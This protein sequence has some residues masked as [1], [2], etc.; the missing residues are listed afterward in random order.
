MFPPE[1]DEFSPLAIKAFEQWAPGAR[2]NYWPLRGGHSGAVVLKVEVRNA[3]DANLESGHYILKLSRYS[4]WSDQ[5]TEIQAHARARNWDQEF[6]QT[7]I[8]AL[9]E[10]FEYRADPSDSGYAML[11][12]IAGSSLDAFGSSEGP[13]NDGFFLVSDRV[14]T[15]LLRHWV[16]R[17]PHDDKRPDEL[18]EMWLGYRLDPAQAGPL[19]SFVS[20][21]MGRDNLI[22]YE[23]G[24]LLLN[25]IKFY[26]HAKE[27]QWLARGILPAMLHQDLYPGNILLHRVD[28]E[29]QPYWIIDFG[30]SV[31]GPAGFDQAYMEV[32]QVINSLG[33]RNAAYL[34][35]VLKQLETPNERRVSPSGTF[36]LKNCLQKMRQAVLSWRDTTHTRRIDD[37]NRQFTLARVAA[38]INW[39]NKP[40]LAESQRVL[41]LCYAGW[42]AREYVRNFEPSD[43]DT[44]ASSTAQKAYSLPEAVITPDQPADEALWEQLWKA[45]GG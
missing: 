21:V 43:W 24:E 13:E 34:V 11:Y 30:L 31:E 42:A 19:H 5:D 6:A 35:G 37:I 25:P 23:A 16:A 18:L 10:K 45:V 38:G 9:I 15:D 8:P 20:S 14:T 12:D 27:R 41:A 1:H 39:A 40:T 3:R 26:E 22:C 32:A 29:G 4:K 2:V 28:P 17:E 33:G 36:W 44:I 7:H